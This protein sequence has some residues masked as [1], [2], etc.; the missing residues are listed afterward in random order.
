MSRQEGGRFG[1][2][3]F[4]EIDVMDSPSELGECLDDLDYQ[5]GMTLGCCKARGGD[6]EG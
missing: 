3:V 2:E 6:V 4:L 5:A 1:H